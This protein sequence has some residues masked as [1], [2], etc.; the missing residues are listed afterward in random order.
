MTE[1]PQQE[2]TI[3]RIANK[4]KGQMKSQTAS[5]DEV[6]ICFL[7]DTT[8]SMEPYIDLL[9]KSIQSLIESFKKLWALDQTFSSPTYSSFVKVA[10]IYY[11]DKIKINYEEMKMNEEEIAEFESSADFKTLKDGEEPK[12]VQFTTDIAAIHKSLNSLLTEKGKIGGMKERNSF[13]SSIGGDDPPEDIKGAVQAAL[14]EKRLEW[15]AKHK[16]LIIITDAPCHGKIYHD[17]SMVDTFPEED[18]S[19]EL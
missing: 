7:I 18:M 16:F 12:I 3:I 13:Y 1:P 10:L 2:H 4:K 8:G 11:K 6:E 9:A 19:N 17:S 14:D 15:K 5:L